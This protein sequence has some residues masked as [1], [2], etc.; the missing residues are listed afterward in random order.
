AQNSNT[1]W[2]RFTA[3]TAGTVRF[4]TFGS[5]YDT[6]LTAY[7]GTCGALT[8]VACEDDA[9]SGLQSEVA[10][11]T[12]AGTTYLIEVAQYG[13]P[14]GGT[15]TATLD[16]LAGCGNGTRDPGEACD[17]GAAN[18]TDRCCSVLCQ[19]IDGDGDGVCDRDDRCPTVVDPGQVDSDD[20]G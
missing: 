3:P 1:V 18:G 15:L 4:D 17:A 20:D 5:S 7:S 2:Y 16:F 9:G 19:V 8:E 10:F 12:T 6:V 13:P 11:T 14:A